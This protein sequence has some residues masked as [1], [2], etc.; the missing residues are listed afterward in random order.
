MDILFEEISQT[1]AAYIWPLFRISSMLMVMTV[2]G[3]NTTP[4]RIRLLL[5]MAITIAV[6]PVLPKT[7]YV[8]L[9]S[10]TA[11]FVSAQQILVGTAIGF[12]TIL[13]MQTFVLTGQIIGMQTS[14]GFA[15]MVDPGSGEQ[16]PVV[17]NFF[18]LLATLIFLSVDGHLLMF[19][20]L[21]ASFETIPVST[22]GFSIANYKKLTEFG[23][24]MFGAALTMSISAIVALLLINL[25]F[26]VMTRASPQLNIFAIGFPV[27]M[28]SGL[29]ILWLTL[30]PIMSHFDQVWLQ[31]Q[32]LMCDILQLTCHIDG[33]IS[34]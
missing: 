23:S 27:T 34:Q 31:A 29:F 22:E 7:T 14:L 19:K 6:A 26:G 3:A 8:E 15:S 5:A 9:F 4:S 33:S 11:V 25:S 32:L 1:I 2:F 28:V 10:L 12:V 24:Y 18:L 16:T 20:M 30:G 13:V 17:G 21:V